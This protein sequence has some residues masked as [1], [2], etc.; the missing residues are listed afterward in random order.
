MRVGLLMKGQTDGSEDPGID[1][2]YT[3]DDK[4]PRRVLATAIFVSLKGNRRL[5]L[6]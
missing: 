3:S 2:T 5:V 1:S 4:F 6:I